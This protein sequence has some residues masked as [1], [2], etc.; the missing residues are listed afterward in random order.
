MEAWCLKTALHAISWLSVISCS[1]IMK[2]QLIN[3]C[4]IHPKDCWVIWEHISEFYICDSRVIQC[5]KLFEWWNIKMITW[6]T[7]NNSLGTH[8]RSTTVVYYV[9]TLVLIQSCMPRPLTMCCVLSIKNE[10]ISFLYWRATLGGCAYACITINKHISLM[11]SK[12]NAKHLVASVKL[13]LKDD[14][15]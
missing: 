10:E 6:L 12:E 1:E 11:V 9:I 7:C 8:Q 5:V 3:Q 13:C 15:T 14:H 2:L 4:N